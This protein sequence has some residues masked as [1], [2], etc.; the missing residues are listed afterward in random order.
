MRFLI[1]R[2]HQ[3]SGKCPYCKGWVVHKRDCPTR[4]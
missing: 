1:I 3:P 2:K 4:R